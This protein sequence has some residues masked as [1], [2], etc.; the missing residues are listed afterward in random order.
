MRDEASEEFLFKEE[1]AT[2]PKSETVSECNQSE[3]IPGL[4]PNQE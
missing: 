3:L 2:P 4:V 1:Q